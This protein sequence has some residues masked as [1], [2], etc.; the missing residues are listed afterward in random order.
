MFNVQNGEVILENISFKLNS[1]TKN[2]L[3][4]ETFP[5]ELIHN[6][7]DVGTGYIWYYIWGSIVNNDDLILL[8][9]C[10]NP[11]KKLEIVEIY[12]Q[13][14]HNMVSDNPDYSKERL[15]LD[16]TVCDNWLKNQY[17]LKVQNKFE[18]GSISSIIDERSWSSFILIKYL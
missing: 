2:E 7:N 18:W 5:K 3:F 12:P 6:I 11:S 8:S 1:N 13:V 16:K 14:L 15:L 17:G 9:L 10:F 4:D